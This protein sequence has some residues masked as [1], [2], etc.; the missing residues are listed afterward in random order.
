[1]A[2]MLDSIE[3]I[4]RDIWSSTLGLDVYAGE[5]RPSLLKGG[6][7]ACVHITGSW[8]GTI[9]LACSQKLAER[10]ARAMFELDDETTH[11]Q[12]DDALCELANMTGGNVKAL[13]PAPCFL[14]LPAVVEGADGTI[15]F[16]RSV[17]VGQVHLDCEGE[18]LVVS[19]HEGVGE[20][21]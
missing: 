14:S 11:E 5:P 6:L 18:P 15:R 17:V 2:T 8:R 21:S 13:L 3:D 4:E 19:V 1:M 9:A 16:P 10:V 7:R 12:R 20:E